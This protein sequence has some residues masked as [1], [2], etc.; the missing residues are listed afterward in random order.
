[1]ITFPDSPPPA[2]LAHFAPHA[3]GLSWLRVR[4]GLSGA[5]VWRGEAGGAPRVALKAWPPGTTPERVL[6]VH[7][8]VS[9]AARLAFVPAIYPGAGG[10]TAFEF[11]GRVWDCCR[12]QPGVPLSAPAVAEVEM[13]CE[14]VAELHR[15]WSVESASG[16]CPGVLNRLRILAEAEPLLRAGADSLP[17]VAP[18]LNPLLRRGAAAVARAA[19]DLARELRP[20]AS[21]EFVLHPCARDLRAAHVLF[22]EN[23][24]TGVI[25]YGA[26]AVDH[27]AVDLARLFTDY[28]PAGDAPFAAGLAAYR[29]SRHTFDAPDDFV[30][31]FLRSGIAC[32][33]AGWLMR[34]AVRRESIHDAAATFARLAQLVALAE[35]V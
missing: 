10:R 1:V 32:S 9:R 6:Q 19:P 12:W 28:A 14:A 4:G 5:A 23:R 16:P 26:M 33:V 17:P 22:D 18:H 24:V 3:R 27:A 2:V 7:G 11:A 13:A 34:L 8:W 21:R 31:L 29:R 25:D 35:K 15:A 20:W 30:R